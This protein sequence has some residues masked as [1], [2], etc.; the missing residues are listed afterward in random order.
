[1]RECDPDPYRGASYRRRRTWR[2]WTRIL[3]IDASVAVS[4]PLFAALFGVQGTWTGFVRQYSYALI[5]ANL[6]GIPLNIA[7]PALWDRTSRWN[8]LPRLGARIGVVVSGT[9]LGCL[10]AGA[11]LYA[12]VGSRYQFWPEFRSSFGISLVLSAVVVGF[13]AL[14]EVQQSRLRESAMRLK[15]NELE[16]ERALKLATEARLSSLESRIHPHFLFNTINSVSSLIHEDPQRAEKVLTQLAAL[17][18]FSLD[19]TQGGLVTLEREL[20][21]VGDYLE[22]EK[23]RFGSR[24][25]YSIRVPEALAAVKVPALAIQTLVENSVKYA[26]SVRGRGASVDISAKELD[27]Q[28]HLSVQDDGPGFSDLRW[29]AGHGL[30]NLQERLHVLFGEAGRVRVT[31]NSSETVVTIELPRML[32]AGP[33]LQKPAASV[34]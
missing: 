34:A 32:A 29:P 4:V 19:S 33:A 16:R 22:I 18:R 17:L 28:V 12:I 1:M 10:L 5:Y 30:D 15:T 13:L 2:W 7:V 11:V 9:F 21:I 6:I 8:P 31:S 26:V 14:Y 20:Q 23:V 25:R 27:G 3:L 24:L